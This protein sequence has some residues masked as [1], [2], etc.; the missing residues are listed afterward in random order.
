MGMAGAV[1]LGRSLS[2]PLAADPEG[3]HQAVCQRAGWMGAACPGKHDA[4]L[5]QNSPKL[6]DE[7]SKLSGCRAL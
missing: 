2:Y 6:S 1:Q 7:R 5:W 3:R 4:A